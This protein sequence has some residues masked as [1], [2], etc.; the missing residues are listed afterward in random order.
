[1]N[2]THLFNQ[3]YFDKYDSRNFIVYERK[4]ANGSG[5]ERFDVRGYYPTLKLMLKE[6]MI[7][8]LEQEIFNKK[9]EEIIEKFDELYEKIKEYQE[10]LDN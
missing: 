5:V 10:R 2:K 6:V 8:Y 9:Y 1:M 4:V 3:Y 7:I